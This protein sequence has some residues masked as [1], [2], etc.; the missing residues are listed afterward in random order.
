MARACIMGL[1]EQGDGLWRIIVRREEIACP[2]GATLEVSKMGTEG[3][4]DFY[5][6]QDDRKMGALWATREWLEE[7]GIVGYATRMLKCPS[8]SIGGR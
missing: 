1:D 5:R 8:R 6:V 7:Q 2:P 4:E 3:L